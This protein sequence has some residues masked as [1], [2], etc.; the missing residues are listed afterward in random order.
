[1]ENQRIGSDSSI[2]G[3]DRNN[4][5]MQRR[6]QAKRFGA[7]VI[8]RAPKSTP[9]LVD[10]V[11][12][13]RNFTELAANMSGLSREEVEVLNRAQEALNEIE[14]MANPMNLR[15]IITERLLGI[16]DM[17]FPILEKHIPPRQDELP[18]SN[19]EE[20]DPED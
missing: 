16:N 11:S 5:Y 6:G 18:E 4:E 10:F 8:D 2:E 20:P 14:E 9:E 13:T 12:S 3:I 1:M 17:V 15:L 19:P 7:M